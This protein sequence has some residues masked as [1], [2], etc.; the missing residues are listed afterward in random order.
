MAGKIIAD[1]LE[2]GAGANIATSYVVNG[3]A[4]AWAATL[5]DSAVAGDSLNI[6]SISDLGSGDNRP[7]WSNAFASSDYSIVA[8]SVW[9]SS[10]NRTVGAGAVTTSQVDL[11]TFTADT[12]NASSVTQNFSCH[13][14]LA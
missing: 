4:K 1:T 3:S 9:T 6:S 10:L 14:D 2:T 12:G 7:S 11:Q 5:T 8:G 13:G